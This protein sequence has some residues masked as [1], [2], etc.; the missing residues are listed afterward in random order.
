LLCSDGLWSV[1]P[2]EAILATLENLPPRSA[3]QHLVKAVYAR[4]A[5]DNVTILVARLR[6]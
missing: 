5:P 4:G 1:I 6:K 3:V 2:E